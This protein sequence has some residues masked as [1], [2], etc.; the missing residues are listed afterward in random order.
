MTKP[1]TSLDVDGRPIHIGDWV[2]VAEVPPTVSAL[3]RSTINVFRSA[4]GKTFQV[5]AF[6][7]RGYP[8]LK[9]DPKVPGLHTIWVEPQFLKVA[10]RPARYS[11]RFRRILEVYRRVYGHYP[12]GTSKDRM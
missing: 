1:P 4:V 10:R 3:P 7:R 9:L 12:Q 8:E 2:R 11:E 6:D 5:E